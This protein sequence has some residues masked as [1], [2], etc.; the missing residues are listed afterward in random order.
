M[1]YVTYIMY[2]K[3]KEYID[4]PSLR[5]YDNAK[6]WIVWQ[7][8]NSKVTKMQLMEFWE[9]DNIKKILF[10]FHS[11]TRAMLYK[12]NHIREH[13]DSLLDQ[14]ITEG[15]IEQ[16]VQDVKDVSEVALCVWPITPFFKLV[17]K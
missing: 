17:V 1:S 6:D 16:Q 14:L 2:Y 3:A 10:D 15:R 7:C 4:Q 5:D 9:T 12:G 8:S 13:L 11:R